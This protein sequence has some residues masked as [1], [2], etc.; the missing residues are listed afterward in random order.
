M[1]PMMMRFFAAAMALAAM[2]IQ[3]KARAADEVALAAPAPALHAG[4]SRRIFSFPTTRP[5]NCPAL[6]RVTAG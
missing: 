4:A 5:G 6:S 3:M 1:T 2:S